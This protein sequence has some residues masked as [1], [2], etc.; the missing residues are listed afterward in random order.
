MWSRRH[1]P[2]ADFDNSSLFRAELV[3]PELS[4]FGLFFNAKLEDGD[5]LRI[6]QKGA[7]VKSSEQNESELRP[8]LSKKRKEVQSVA[9]H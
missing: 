3:S 4:I 2:E 6:A 9:A 8:G 1:S 5:P 7:T